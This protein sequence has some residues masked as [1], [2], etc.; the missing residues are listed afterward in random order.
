MSFKYTQKLPNYI[1]INQFI[2]SE[3][4]KS[5]NLLFVDTNI[6]NFYNFLL[7]HVLKSELLI[8]K[9]Y[10]ISSNK[11]LFYEKLYKYDDNFC[12]IYGTNLNH[13]MSLV[14]NLIKNHQDIRMLSNNKLNN[15]MIIIIL[16]N[17]IYKK[18]AWL[19]KFLSLGD[20]YNIKIL[21]YSNYLPLVD[22]QIRNNLNMIMISNFIIDKYPFTCSYN[23]LKYLNENYL[24]NFINTIEL[25]VL[26]K[27]IKDKQLLCI[28]YDNNNYDKHYFITLKENLQE[29]DSDIDTDE[30]IETFIL[31]L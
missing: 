16:D 10:F 2:T 7:Q 3:L 11:H 13:N 14:F 27:N 26:L 22:T 30:F 6:N 23:K 29:E 24:T 19:K 1:E 25:R 18:S 21:I 8:N 31:E 12:E 28:T 15:Y 4:K 5:T 9:S 20:K 17:Y